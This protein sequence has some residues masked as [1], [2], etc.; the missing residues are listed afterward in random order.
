MEEF[1]KQC[2]LANGTTNH[3]K[4]IQLYLNESD[5]ENHSYKILCAYRTTDKDCV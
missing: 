4:E 2:I 5:D 1:Y 3:K